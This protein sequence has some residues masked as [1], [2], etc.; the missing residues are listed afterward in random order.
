MGRR[1]GASGSGMPGQAGHDG[2]WRG[3]P[4]DECRERSVASAGSSGD[5]NGDRRVQERSV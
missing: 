1:S 4:G 2:E 3:R 5:R